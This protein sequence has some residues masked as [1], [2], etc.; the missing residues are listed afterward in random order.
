LKEIIG[1]RETHDFLDALE[2][3]IARQQ[4]A[5]MLDE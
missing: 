2:T 1:V 4:D 3:M 5:L